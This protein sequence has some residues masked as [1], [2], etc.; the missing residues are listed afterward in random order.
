[1]NG[2][3]SKYYEV[4]GGS[5]NILDITDDEHSL[6]IHLVDHGFS[7]RVDFNKIFKVSIIENTSPS[8]LEFKE[9]RYI[10]LLNTLR[11]HGLNTVNPFGLRLLY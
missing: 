9:N 11:P 5:S 6:G 2:H 3:R 8:S 7:E 10:H 4:I 1:M